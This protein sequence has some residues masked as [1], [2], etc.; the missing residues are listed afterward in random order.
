MEKFEEHKGEFV[1][2]EEGSEVLEEE[3]CSCVEESRKIQLKMEISKS[4]KES[5]F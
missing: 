5:R 3:R 1:G 2:G 4:Q